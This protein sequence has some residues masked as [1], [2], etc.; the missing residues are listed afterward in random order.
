MVTI[1]EAI[2]AKIDK[3]GK[4]FEILVDPALAYGLKEGK[5]VSIQNMIAVNDVYTDSKKGEKARDT[6]VSEVFGTN[7]IEKVAEEIVKKGEVQ[8]TTEF[9]NKKVDEKKKQ[10][11]NFISKNAIN[12]QTKVPHPQERIL[13]AMT[14][15]KVHVDP[16]KGAESQID[17]VID[18][19]RSI[20]P[21]SIE[22]AEITIE[23]P[24]QYS[25]HAY[26]FIKGLGDIKDQQW[27]NDGSLVVRLSIPAGMKE[28]IYR[29]INSMTAGSANITEK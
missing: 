12:P 26:G 17:S 28:D 3:K 7:D 23:V 9:R 27:K 15:A 22:Q 18:A 10:I 8:L 20:L 1:D 21:I 16:F 5:S 29:K 25:A 6:D 14:Q 11:A 24:A 2:I 13:N 19:I 4:H